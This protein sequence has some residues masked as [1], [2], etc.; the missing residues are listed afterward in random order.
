M[1]D[2]DGRALL[3]DLDMAINKTN[4]AI[5]EHEAVV[6]LTVGYHNLLRAWADA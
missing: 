5:P 1:R 6:A 3:F 4:Q 2:D